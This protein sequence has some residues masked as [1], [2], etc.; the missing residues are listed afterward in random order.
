MARSREVG[1]KSGLKWLKNL[2]D[3]LLFFEKK[4]KNFELLRFF[5]QKNFRSDF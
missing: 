3:L 2:S 5:Y 4:F 1:C